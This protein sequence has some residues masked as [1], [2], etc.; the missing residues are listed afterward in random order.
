MIAAE[1]I[2]IPKILLKLFAATLISAFAGGAIA[3]AQ[4][5]LPKLPK[6]P[7]LPG[8]KENKPSQESK[9]KKAESLPAPELTAITPDAA[10][11]GGAGELVLTGKNFTPGMNIRFNCKGGVNPH[12][13]SFKVENSSRAVANVSLPLN[14]AECPCEM[15][16]ERTAGGSETGE[17]QSG[18]KEVF[19]VPASGP[20]F[21]I[22]NSG[23]LPVSVDVVLLAEGNQDFPQ[24]M[25][26]LQQAMMPGFGEKA[27]KTTLLLAPDT[28]KYV[29]GQTTLFSEPTSAVKAVEEMSM[30]GQSM[31]IFRIEFKD[32]K[33]YNFMGAQGGSGDS[34]KAGEIVKKRLGK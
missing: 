5:G 30:M 6:I 13:E 19:Q 21:A 20:K 9:P 1:G 12:I 31:G 18:T 3:Y 10:P 28:V 27:E 15:F 8:Q 11:P 22:S 4:F 17:S 7:K 34:K 29:R 25:M 14:A 16:L 2:R 33:I 26:K 24:L 23:S 32:G